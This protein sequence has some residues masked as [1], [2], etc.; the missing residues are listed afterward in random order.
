MGCAHGVD[1]HFYPTAVFT[2]CMSVKTGLRRASTWASSSKRKLASVWMVVH[3]QLEGNSD[4]VHWMPAHTS[5]GMVGQAM[6]S[7][8][9]PMCSTR[10]ASNQIVDLMAKDAAETVRV[11][12]G[13][14]KWLVHRDSQ[15]C[16][17]LKYLGKLTFEVNNFPGPGGSAIRDSS[18]LPKRFPRSGRKKAGRVV[19]PVEARRQRRRAR[20]TELGAQG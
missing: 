17:L 13:T 6:C 5:V 10:W 20:G 12:A 2:D 1:A 7:D 18:P 4:I 15:L 16:E 3:D 8:G 11:S 19:D 9:M 14:R